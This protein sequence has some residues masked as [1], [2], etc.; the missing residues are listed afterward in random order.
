MVPET[1]ATPYDA[2]FGAPGP[3]YFITDSFE[4]NAAMAPAI[5]NAG[6]RHRMT[7]SRAYHLVSSSASNTALSKRGVPTGRKY[8]PAKTAASHAKIFNS[9][10]I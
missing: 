9:C 3:R 6:N 4:K 1:E 2:T 8:T 5:Q 10:F 7:C